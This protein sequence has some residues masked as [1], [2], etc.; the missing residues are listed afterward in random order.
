M[1]NWILFSSFSTEG[2]FGITFSGTVL[3]SRPTSVNHFLLTITELLED[4][5]WSIRSAILTLTKL[6]DPAGRP[7]L[8][9]VLLLMTGREYQTGIIRQQKNA[10]FLKTQKQMNDYRNKRESPKMYLINLK[11]PKNTIYF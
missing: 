9:L 7:R 3:T 1:L 10:F 5:K 6:V 2:T 8:R 11:C 4:P